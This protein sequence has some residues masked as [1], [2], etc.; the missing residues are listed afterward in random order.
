MRGRV[1]RMPGRAAL[2]SALL[3]AAAAGL[4][5]APLAANA[6]TIRC[7]GGIVSVG[8]PKIDLLGKCGPPALREIR[9]GGR[10]RFVLGF[11]SADVSV[12]T[13]SYDFGPR[14]FLQIVTIVNGRVTA[15]ERG[16]YGYAAGGA[17][18]PRG[19]PVSTC[20]PAVLDE[21]DTKLDVLAQCGEPATA[22]VWEEERGYA[23][24]EP[25]TSAAAGGWFTVLREVWTYNFGPRRF[26]RLVHFENGKVTRVETGGYGYGE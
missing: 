26:L 4:A 6:D 18:G 17:A 24:V 3:A 20:D 10:S 22:D 21:G 16:G 23:V 13:W 14:Q 15:I 7:Q 12:E 1:S 8:D 25:G 11:Q 19:V 5:G 9:H 2:C